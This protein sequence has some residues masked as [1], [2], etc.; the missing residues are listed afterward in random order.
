MPICSQIFIAASELLILLKA[1]QEPADQPF[2]LRNSEGGR[3]V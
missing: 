1:T 2:T 3:R